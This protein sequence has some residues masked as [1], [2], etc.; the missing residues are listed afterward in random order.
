ME[1]EVLRGNA[2]ILFNIFDVMKE[3]LDQMKEQYS[4][5]N[6]MNIGS[7]KKVCVTSRQIRMISKEIL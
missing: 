4:K 3:H 1:R 6:H 2:R 7:Y 5:N